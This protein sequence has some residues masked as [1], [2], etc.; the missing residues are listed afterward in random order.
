MRSAFFVRES[1]LNPFKLLMPVAIVVVL[2]ATAGC[3]ECL[4]RCTDV[5]C[6]MDGDLDVSTDVLADNGMDSVEDVGSD[7]GEPPAPITSTPWTKIS[8]ATFVRGPFIQMGDHDSSV[9]VWRT[10]TPVQDEGCVDYRHGDFT[11]RRCAS[12]DVNGQYEVELSDLPS[13]TEVFYSVSTG[14]NQTVE[15]SFRTLPMESKP[16]KILV[17]ADAH[18]N[19]EALA[20]MADVALAEGVDLGVSVGDQAS[21]PTDEEYAQYFQGLRDIASRVTIWSV[22]GN[23]D[24]YDVRMFFESVVLPKGSTSEDDLKGGYAEGYWDARLGNTWIGGGWV[25]DFYIS[26]PDVDWG[27][28]GF[29]RQR[30]ESE[31]YKT[32]AWRLFFIHQP[33]WVA[34]WPGC[35]YTGEECL[36]LSMIPMVRDGGVDATFHGH[37]HGVEWGVV[38]GVNTFVIGG[39]GGDNDPGVCAL[40]EDWP[41]PWSRSYGSNSFAIVE[42]GDDAMSVR[43]FSVG[44]EGE[45][46]IEVPRVTR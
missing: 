39:V 1:A 46:T 43:V 17:F 9:I 16:L 7:P 26:P 27:E 29:F 42:T 30:F 5:V 12:P 8:D 19:P 3:S 6:G 40:P 45:F 35:D 23:H 36:K 11:G 38:E 10:E 41:L 20:W 21:T 24:D 4:N 37:M 2:T 22:P 44:E 13:E 25:R 15:L 18:N 31:E 32:A 34:E 28:V 33:A 14:G